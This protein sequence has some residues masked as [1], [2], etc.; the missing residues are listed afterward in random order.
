ME[1]KERRSIGWA[2][3]ERM[4][5]GMRWK[6]LVGPYRQMWAHMIWPMSGCNASEGVIFYFNFWRG[7]S[8]VVGSVDESEVS[9]GIGIGIGVGVGVEIVI[10]CGMCT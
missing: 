3:N 8:P 10:G 1:G 6:C 9:I 4:S 7:P 2:L 5:G